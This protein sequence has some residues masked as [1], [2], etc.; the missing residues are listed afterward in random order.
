MLIFWLLRWRPNGDRHRLGSTCLKKLL[1]DRSEDYFSPSRLAKIELFGLRRT[2]NK[3]S[4]DNHLRRK[5]GRGE[6]LK[7]L[8]LE[9]TQFIIP[10]SS[11]IFYKAS[12]LSRFERHEISRENTAAM[13]SLLYA[14]LCV[15]TLDDHFKRS[16]HKPT[17]L[18]AKRF[19][20]SAW[21][22][23]WYPSSY[24]IILCRR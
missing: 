20:R 9:Q 7:I 22:W 6:M 21:R 19:P 12:G 14:T 1:L 18:R 10:L 13:W 4:A 24:L 3:C 2:S 5:L 16:R 11:V 8:K 15:H 17:Y 23:K